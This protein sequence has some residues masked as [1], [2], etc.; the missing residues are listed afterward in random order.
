MNFFLKNL[1]ESVIDILGN[2]N[3]EIT[4]EYICKY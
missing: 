3:P 4:Y 1:Y 2:R